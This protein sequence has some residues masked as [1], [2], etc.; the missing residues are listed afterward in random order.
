MK[1]HTMKLFRTAGSGLGRSA[2]PFE[3]SALAHFASLVLPASVSASEFDLAIPTI[4]TSIRLY[5]VQVSGL[6]M[7]TYANSRTAF[8]ALRGKQLPVYEIPLQAGMSIG[9]LLI[10]VELIMMLVILMFVP[11]E[12]A[13]ASFL[14][15]AIGESLGASALRIAGGI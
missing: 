13:G 5:G 1:E 7:N 9:V 12:A 10:C 6:T 11:R 4:D 2:R 15:F 14:G 3:L 8:A